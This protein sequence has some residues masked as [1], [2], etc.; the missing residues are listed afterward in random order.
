MKPR[1]IGIV[2][3]GG[4]PVGSASVL[5]DILVECQQKYHSQRSYEFPCI[6][7]YSYPYSETLLANNPSSIPSRELSYCIQQLKLIGMEVIVVPCFTMSSYLTYRNYGVELIEMGTFMQ[8]YLEKNKIKNPLVISSDRTRASGYCNKF[9]DC[10]YPDDDLQQEISPLIEAALRG[11]K[12]SV[13]ALMDLL[14]DTP[15]LCAMTVVNAQIGE[16]DDSRWIN[17]NKL[18]AKYV[19]HRSYEGEENSSFQN[20]FIEIQREAASLSI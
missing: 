15:I 16:V 11:E 20:G 17:P 13:H 14:P 4:G 12:I 10:H 6:N 19:V 2:A 18:V 5:Q 9:F 8:L 1:A 7:F 3:G